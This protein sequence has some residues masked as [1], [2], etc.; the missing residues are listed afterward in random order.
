[1]VSHATRRAARHED[2]GLDKREYAIL[3]R[4][5]TPQRIQAF[6]DAIPINYERSEEHTSE[7]QSRHR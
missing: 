4:L 7:L 5:R 1:M 3:R 2:L 6:V